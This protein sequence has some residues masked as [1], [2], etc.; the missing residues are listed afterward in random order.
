MSGGN[1]GTRAKG[2]G[3][4]DAEEVKSLYLHHYRQQC[5]THQTQATIIKFKYI[6][7]KEMD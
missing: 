7:F 3:H 1:R 6:S 4:I 5:C 2:L